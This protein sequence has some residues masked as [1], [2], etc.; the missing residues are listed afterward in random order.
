MQREKNQRPGLSH[1]QSG[2]QSPPALLPSFLT[3]PTF[4]KRVNSAL[5]SLPK[6][7]WSG[8][9]SNEKLAARWWFSCSAG[10]AAQSSQ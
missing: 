2:Q 6:K 5:E 9:H 3:G 10:N 1:P 4:R 8:A 7:S